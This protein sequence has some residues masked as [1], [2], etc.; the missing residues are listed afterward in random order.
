MMFK[1]ICISRPIVSQGIL[2]IDTPEKDQW[3]QVQFMKTLP[4][5]RVDG[6]GQGA[7]AIP[8][9][10]IYRVESIT[11]S[12]REAFCALILAIEG[13]AILSSSLAVVMLFTALSDLSLNSY[14][15]SLPGSLPSA[16]PHRIARSETPTTQPTVE[17]QLPTDQTAYRHRCRCHNVTLSGGHLQP[18]FL[19][20][21]KQYSDST[22]LKEASPVIHMQGSRGR[23]TLASLQ[24][25]GC[26]LLLLKVHLVLFSP[27][28]R[29]LQENC[30]FV[31]IQN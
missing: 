17:I 24:E 21:Q 16:R 23:S 27:P 4:E 9:Q 28:L 13:R 5:G 6:N 15:L 18:F 1:G 31:E 2:F 12:H 22:M 19:G 26:C 20:Q 8:Q 30:D 10:V 29:V 11:I 7:T 25:H 14:P 3:Q